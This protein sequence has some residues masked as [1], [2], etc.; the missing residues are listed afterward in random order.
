MLDTIHKQCHGEA[1]QAALG[2][3]ILE[4][5]YKCVGFHGRFEKS[6]TTCMRSKKRQVLYM[7]I[8]DAGYCCRYVH[9]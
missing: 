3:L 4:E 9:S 6:Q 2:M 7:E 5:M 8:A 1:K